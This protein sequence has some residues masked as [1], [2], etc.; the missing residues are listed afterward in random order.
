M[1][2]ECA[3]RTSLPK[4][5]AISCT[6]AAADNRARISEFKGAWLEAGEDDEEARGE[7][8]EAAAAMGSSDGGLDD[9]A[10]GA[11]EE[12]DV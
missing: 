1:T 5:K 10:I 7:D 2:K 11:E 9:E 3:G 12:E 8:E 4:W 6:T